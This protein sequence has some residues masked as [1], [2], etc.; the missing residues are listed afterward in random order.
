MVILWLYELNDFTTKKHNMYRLQ[1]FF[2]VCLDLMDKIAYCILLCTVGGILL[3]LNFFA[4]DTN[5]YDNEIITSYKC[6]RYLFLSIAILTLLFLLKKKYSKI[7]YIEMILWFI[8]FVLAP[9]LF[10]QIP[11]VSNAYSNVTYIR[12]FK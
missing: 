1:H 7:T 10:H 3:N 9:Y 6:L 11:S 8:L 12:S 4:I 5:Q 2:S